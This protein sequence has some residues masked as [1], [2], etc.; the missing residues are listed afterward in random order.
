MV[1]VRYWYGTGIDMVLVW[2]WYVHGMVLA[3]HLGGVGMGLVLYWRGIGISLS[4]YWYGIGIV[5]V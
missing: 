5:W 4:L 2:R 1:F 3:R